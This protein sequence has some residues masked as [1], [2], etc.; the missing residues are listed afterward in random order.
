M[1]N[2]TE[3]VCVICCE[4]IDEYT[5]KNVKC[6]QCFIIYHYPCFRNNTISFRTLK[7]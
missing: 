2:N 6:N 7:K 5:V 1:E 4:I 3:V